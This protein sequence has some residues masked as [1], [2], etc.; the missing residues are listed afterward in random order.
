MC[1]PRQHRAVPRDELFGSGPDPP[2]WLRLLL[3]DALRNT[4]SALAVTVGDT[5]L[6]LLTDSLL[7]PV[8]H[9]TVLQRTGPLVTRLWELLGPPGGPPALGAPSP[10]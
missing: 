9:T 7:P 6:R 4:A 8:L 3:C 2:A 5:V 1:P 10:V